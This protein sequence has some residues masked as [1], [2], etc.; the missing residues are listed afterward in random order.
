MRSERSSLY[1]D[2]VTLSN[3]LGVDVW[4]LLVKRYGV[5]LYPVPRI[6][7]PPW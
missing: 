2:T 1:I 6:F 5:R 3:F 4:P 7:T